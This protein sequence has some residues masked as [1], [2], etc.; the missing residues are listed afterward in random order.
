MATKAFYKGKVRTFV[1]PFGD[2][3]A[4]AQRALDRNVPIGRG[5]PWR[6]YRD[7]ERYDLPNWSRHA[8]TQNVLEALTKY[9]S[10][11]VRHNPYKSRRTELL[12][13]SLMERLVK[14]FLNKHPQVT[15]QLPLVEVNDWPVTKFCRRQASIMKDEGLSEEESYQ[16]VV[17]DGGG[18]GDWMGIWETLEHDRLNRLLQKVR[19]NPRS[20]RTIQ[21]ESNRHANR[22]AKGDGES[23]EAEATPS[24]E[25]PGNSR[26]EILAKNSIVKEGISLVETYSLMRQLDLLEAAESKLSGTKLNSSRGDRFLKQAERYYNTKETAKREGELE[27]LKR[28]LARRQ[29]RVL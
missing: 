24:A 10:L 21:W 26:E 5:H 19:L 29:A 14:S 12:S 17:E 22:L 25:A 8:W 11:P 7:R 6:V 4:R 2:I 13:E 20:D 3:R 16:R 27:I 18:G 1:V 9:P 28:V 23:S 15:W